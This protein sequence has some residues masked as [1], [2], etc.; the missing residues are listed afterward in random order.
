MFSKVNLPRLT[1]TP[2]PKIVKTIGLGNNDGEIQRSRRRYFAPDLAQATPP[3]PPHP[4]R[5]TP[6][7]PPAPLQS[8]SAFRVRCRRSEYGICG[9]YFAPRGSGFRAKV[10]NAGSFSCLTTYH[11]HRY[12]HDQGALSAFAAVAVNAG[13][14]ENY[15]SLADPAFARR[16]RTREASPASLPTTSTTTTTTM[17]R[18]SFPRSLPSQR[19]WDP[20]GIICPS[21]IQRSRE[22]S[23]RG[24]LLLPHH[25]HH[26]HRHH[27]EGSF[28]RS[29]PSQ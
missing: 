15:L 18:E 4:L 14:A 6:P 13:F 28:P 11:H 27:Q 22:G 23:E 26:H 25:H 20:W 1:F 19:M 3:Q 8:W 24:K 17:I 5:N 21:R 10:A 12:H 7:P 9:E 16:Q 29:L 2:T